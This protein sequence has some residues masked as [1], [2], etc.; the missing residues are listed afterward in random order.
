MLA[1]NKLMPQEGNFW[2]GTEPLSLVGQ[3]GNEDIF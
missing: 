1:L 2:N 3:M